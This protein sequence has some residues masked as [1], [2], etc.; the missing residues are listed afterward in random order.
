MDRPYN[1]LFLCTGNSSRSI[2]AEALV[3]KLG[4][5]R[6]VAFSAGTAPKGEV[7][8]SALRLVKDLGIDPSELRS[9][10]RDEFAAPDAPPLDFVVTLSDDA[11][12]EE[13]PE[14]PGQPISAHWAIPDPALATGSDAE[15]IA[16]FAETCRMLR[17][18]IDLLLNLPIASL[19]RLSLQTHLHEIGKHEDAPAAS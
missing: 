9:K 16:V 13:S 12:G 14:W 1:I 17:N 4:S 19:D 2:L 8:P 6:Y 10:S 11:A 5:G 3:K 7:N 18:R 15:I